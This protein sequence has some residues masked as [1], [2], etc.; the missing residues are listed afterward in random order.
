[1]RPMA[2]AEPVVVGTSA[3]R[4][5]RA[6]RRSRCGRSAIVCVF[7]A[8]WTVVIEPWRMPIS[9]CSTLTTG[10]RQLVV[11]LAAVTTWC[12]SGS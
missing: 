10:A 12:S 1:M 2:V 3:F 4:A 11:Q 8:L 5:E 6:R 7:V 9:S